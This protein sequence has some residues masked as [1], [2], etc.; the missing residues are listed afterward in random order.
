MYCM[1][2]TEGRFRKN[3]QQNLQI[4][5]NKW[6]EDSP[7]DKFFYQPVPEIPVD[8]NTDY[9]GFL[10]V[11]QTEFQSRLLIKYGQEIILMD[12]TYNT[13]QYEMPLHLICFLT[14]VG[15]KVVGAFVIGK[16][17]RLNIKE[18]FAVLKKWNPGWS[19]NYFMCDNDGREIGA[20]ENLFEDCTVALCD[21]RREQAW[22][23]WLR[24]KKHHLSD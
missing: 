24:E 3:D 18:G 15:Y 1:L 19:P 9:H 7:K 17:S 2:T 20:I 8:I 16:E 11:H 14:N 10:F 13:M 5:V 22:E 12:S 23:R 4:L 6:K 21:F